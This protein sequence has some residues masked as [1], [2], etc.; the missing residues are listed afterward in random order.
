MSG[1]AA[2]FHPQGS[3]VDKELIIAM[4]SLM[5]AR[6]P[7]QQHYWHNN[8]IALAHCLLA[9]GRGSQH[10]QQ[11]SHLNHQCWISGDIRIDERHSL[12]NKIRQHAPQVNASNTDDQLLLHAYQ[13]WGIECLQHIIGDFAFVLWDARKQRLFCATDQFGVAPLYYAET[14]EGICVSNTLNAIRLHPEVSAELD[15]LAIAD[16]LLFRTNENNHST[17]FKH[18][19]HVPAGH[20]LLFEDGRC[21]LSRYWQLPSRDRFYRAKAET[22]V[23]EFHELLSNAVADRTRCQN[24][25]T[26]LSG[27]MDSSSITVLTHQLMM[28]GNLPDSIQAYTY[29]A[30]GTLDDL[31]SPLAQKVAQQLTIKHHIVTTVDEMQSPPISPSLF[32]PEPRFL[33]REVGAY[34]L[35]KMVATH[36][37]V[38]LSGH[39]GDPLLRGNSLSK[40]DLGSINNMGFLVKQAWHHYQWF[41]KRPPLGLRKKQ[42]QGHN[43]AKEVPYWFNPDFADRNQLSEHIQ[44]CAQARALDHQQSMG[45]GSL[46]RRIFCWNDPGFTHIPVKVQYP[47]FDV[48]LLEFARSL[49]PF[50]WLHDKMILRRTM[51][52]ALPNTITRRPK[53]P[54]PGNGLESILKERN[55]IPEHFYEL[56]NQT[57]VQNYIETTQLKDKLNALDQCKKSDYKAIIRALTLSYWLEGYEKTDVTPQKNQ[58]KSHVKRITS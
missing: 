44:A 25:A 10:Q 42:T 24:V 35:L 41:G 12:V 8:H 40:Q 33:S 9:T 45:S 14:R 31:E 37:S 43:R 58:G 36:S 23:E 26:Q 16:Y 2:L 52:N 15:E 48:R 6:G 19:K 49:P 29:G 20:Y 38:L 18:I 57:K 51:Q 13:I 17:S 28:Q 27:G 30:S 46:W 22:Y 53:T 4:A 34:Q 7:E 11:P 54:L 3:T 21:R 39:G 32:F 50:P 5:T 47:F 1:I 56:L 55:T